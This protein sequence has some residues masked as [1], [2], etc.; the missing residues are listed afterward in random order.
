MRKPVIALLL[1]LPLLAAA[2]GKVASDQVKI[3][4]DRRI[5][6]RMDTGYLTVSPS[7]AGVITYR[8]KFVPDETRSMFRFFGGVG[9]SQRDYDDCS[10]IFDAAKG[11]LTIRTGKHLDAVVTVEVPAQQPLDLNLADG[12]IK[13]GAVSGKLD[14]FINDGIIK[15]DASALAPGACVKAAINDGVVENKRDFPC[16]TASATLHGHSGIISVK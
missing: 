7:A 15:Y 2:E 6:V 11:T 1:S 5:S 13:I 12:E 4:A 8:V 14:A 9:P 3:E 16:E 10:A